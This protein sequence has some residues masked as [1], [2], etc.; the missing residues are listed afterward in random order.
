MFQEFYYDMVCNWIS[1]YCYRIIDFTF[2]EAYSKEQ[3]Q[4][5]KSIKLVLSLFSDIPVTIS[6]NF[7]TL[8]GP[9]GF[10]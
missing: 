7:L 1:K 5:C 4:W 3:N 10:M 9:H 6:H 2:F 8:P